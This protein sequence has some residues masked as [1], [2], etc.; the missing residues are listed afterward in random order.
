MVEKM[1]DE[2][3]KQRIIYRAPKILDKNHPHPYIDKPRGPSKLPTIIG[4][5][6]LVLAFVGTISIISLIFT[7]INDKNIAVHKAECTRFE[8]LLQPVVEL[9]PPPFEKLQNVSPHLIL[10]SG[11]LLALETN[12]DKLKTDAVGKIILPC[13][14]IKEA[15]KK[16]F[17]NTVTLEYI[18]F[19]I[20]ENFFDYDETNQCYYVPIVGNIGYYAPA[21]IDFTKKS[22]TITLT[23]G[24]KNIE[25]GFSSSPVK[26]MTYIL[27]G[28]KGSETISSITS[29]NY[30]K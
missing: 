14:K 19:D 11:I 12:Q 16:L 27:T 5:L 2:P 30:K 9:D 6:V 28:K 15:T 17:G 3:T 10:Q 20:S 22:N 26:Y 24:Y 7:N 29:S 1:T 8:Q 21:V 23:V 4:A 13:S 18:S 25:D